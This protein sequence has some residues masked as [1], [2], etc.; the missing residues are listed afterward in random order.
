MIMYGIHNTQTEE[1]LVNTLE[2]MHNNT[3]WNKNYLWVNLLI[4]LIGIYQRREWYI[5]L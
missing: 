3:T 4:G 2:K 1:N 5:L